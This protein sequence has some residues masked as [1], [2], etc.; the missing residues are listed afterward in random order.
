M[1][2]RIRV[3]RP[4]RAAVYRRRPP[5]AWAPPLL[6]VLVLASSAAIIA[7]RQN[8]G[9]GLRDLSTADQ[10][11]LSYLD[12]LVQREASPPARLVYPYSVVPGGVAS[13]AEVVEA[14]RRDPV[15][16]RHYAG[17]DPRRARTLTLAVPR[18][19]YVSYRIK[20][21]VFF[22]RKPVRLFAGEQVITDGVTTIRARCGNK[23]EEAPQMV[24]SEQEPPE[25]VLNSPKLEPQPEER[26][27][28]LSAPG[29]QPGPAPEETPLAAVVPPPGFTPLN[30]SPRSPVATWLM[31]T[32]P[33]GGFL[34][35]AASSAPGPGAS[36]PPAPPTEPG[37]PPVP[38]VTPPPVT[39]PPVTPPGNT[40]P[41]T[42]PTPTPQP[43][44]STPPSAPP[45][46][47][48]GTPGGPPVTPAPVPS[49]SG[50]GTPPAQPPTITPEPPPIPV[51][52][53]GSE[54][55]PPG[56]LPPPLLPP[57]S[58]P[59]SPSAELPPEIVIP[60][61]DGTPPPGVPEPQPI[62]EPSTIALTVL[63]LLAIP[64]WRRIQGSSR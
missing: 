49:P 59:E 25:H 19:A 63:G 14:M 64:A 28:T 9:A 15:V 36:Q 62:P 53:P 20:D 10:R 60:P 31:P 52:P 24:V 44:P 39:P 12:R 58:D 22:T 21:K 37:T 4:R 6:A 47:P 5:A 54:V 43:P 46:T 50:P 3:R 27:A 26:P 17:F 33:G 18:L 35:P 30:V 38:P 32:M 42:P 57:P 41:E 61:P 7:V 56:P 13:P 29:I 8:G 55:P 34:P 23:V 40:P 48:P 16:A 1:K 45:S 51:P 11:W 2:I